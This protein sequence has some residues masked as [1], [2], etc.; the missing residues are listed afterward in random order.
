MKEVVDK[1]GGRQDGEKT[2]SVPNPRGSP[3]SILI[4]TLPENGCPPLRETNINAVHAS[5]KTAH[6]AKHKKHIGGN[7]C[8]F[9]I[10]QSVGPIR[11]FFLLWPTLCLPRVN[12]YQQLLRG[13]ILRLP[14]KYLLR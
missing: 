11:L 7:A 1:N 13:N 2:G 5:G 12:E 3:V 10:Q 6:N 9:A 8:I 14:S 4:G